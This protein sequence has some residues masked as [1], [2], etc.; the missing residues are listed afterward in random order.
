MSI[1]I[2]LDLGQSS[3]KTTG[4]KGSIIFPS[5]AALMGASNVVSL[6]SKRK[7]N[8]PMVV[9][10]LY[11]GHNAHRDG[12]PLENFSFDRLAG[13]TPEMR[14]ILHGTLTEY[15]HKFGLF[16]EDVQMVVGLPMQML[17]GD[18]IVVEK[19]KSGVKRWIGG[20]HEWTADGE[21]YALD[22]TRVDLG[23]QAL[24]ALFDY[25]LT[26]DGMPNG[27]AGSEAMKRECAM[28][29]IGSNTV[30][31]QV[32]KRNDD[33]VRFNGGKPIGVRWLHN[34]VDPNTMWTFG[35]FDQMLRAGELPDEIEI[36][37]FLGAWATQVLDFVN[38]K[39]N[40]AFPRFHK[41]FIVGGGSLL[42]RPYLEA[43]FNGK[44]VFSD[45][46]ILSI[47]RGLY[48]SALRVK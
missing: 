33:T 34:Q 2:G 41:I 11:V 1:K 3:V 16:D 38:K 43:K 13:V 40:D 20:H 24:G 21:P 25:G 19:Y 37:S 4:A 28:I 26:M 15:Q 48:K 5:L 42:L 12:I 22:V 18:E 10:G 45:D 30:E 47:S 17:F 14:A 35:E 23:P 6:T 27:S 31:L 36:E 8:A 9:D 7:R 29:S 46:P 39:W 44:A 32:T